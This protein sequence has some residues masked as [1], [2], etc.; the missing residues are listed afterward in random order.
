MKASDFQQGFP[1]RLAPT[2][3]VE[4]R[5]GKLV[6]AE[7][8]AFV[9]DPLPP[10]LDR[11]SLIGDLYEDLDRAKT[12]LLRLEAEVRRLPEP[13]VLLSAMRS[14][15][16]QASS[17]IENTFASL[18][19]IALAEI[20]PSS[21]R[22]EAFEVRRNRQSIE[23]GLASRLP[24]SKRLVFEMHKVL[25]VDSRHRPGHLRDRQVC[26][27][28]ENRGFSH[29]RFV[30]PPASELDACLKDWELF[31]NPQAIDAP[32]RER[33]PYLIELAMSH[34]Q[35]ETIH[36]FS[37]GNG[38]LGR[39]LVN[40]APVKDQFLKE[41]V[42]NLSEWVQANR[43]EYYDRFLRVST[44]SEWTPWIRFFCIALAEQADMDLER[45]GRVGR[46]H[47]KYSKLVSG[48]RKSSLIAK[49][50]DHLFVDHAITIPSAVGLLGIT[51]PAAQRHVEFLVREGVLLQ[52]GDSKYGKMFYARNIVRAI[53][54][55]GE[56]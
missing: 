47:Q 31:A 18:K 51:Y 26:I 1:G 35:F 32:Q 27:G 13:K 45:A 20:D 15:E 11:R 3:F 38:R 33:W 30:P 36:P 49:L 12:A 28:D 54:G 40:V 2:T 39:A 19:E 21:A 8:L 17:R 14:S 52:I 24:I 6:S 55:K 22:E 56:E 5:E 48:A 37:D 23:A 16:S 25:V 7:G 50:V 42:C 9:P 10:K 34:Y 4:K 53:H 44:H 29:A 46:L 43:Q 41:P